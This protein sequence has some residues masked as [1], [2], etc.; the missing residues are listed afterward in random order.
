[1]TTGPEYLSIEFQKYGQKLSKFQAFVY[2][3]PFRVSETWLSNHIFNNEMLPTGYTIY[4]KDRNSHGGGVLMAIK[5]NL[6]CIL[7]SFPSDLEIIAVK[8][9]TSNPVFIYLVY[10]M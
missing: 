3:Q 5:D 1:M 2:S 10:I 9:S 7:V 4:R 8:I 6:T